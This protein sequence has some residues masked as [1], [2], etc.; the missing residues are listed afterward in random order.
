MRNRDESH[1]YIEVESYLPSDL[2]NI[3]GNIEV[4]AIQGAAYP[5]T[6]RVQAPRG[7]SENHPLG[8]KFRIT[9]QVIDDNNGLGAY[10]RV[11]ESFPYEVVR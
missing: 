11:P 7:L 3:K 4:R 1:L 9:V 10:L 8:T 6:M 5:P 2:E